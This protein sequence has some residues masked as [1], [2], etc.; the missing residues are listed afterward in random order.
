MALLPIGASLYVGGYFSNYRGVANSA[1][2]LAKL[3]MSDGSIDTLFSQPGVG[4]NGVGSGYVVSLATVGS[5][6]FIGGNFTDYRGVANSANAI[7][8]LSLGDGAIDTTFSP[9]GNNGF[10][11]SVNS[12][13][14]D[15]TSLYVGGAITAYRSVSGSIKY[16]AKLSAAD[17]SLDT[18][19]ITLNATRGFNSTV[20]CL[21]MAGT[22]VYVGGYFS[23]YD[24]GAPL[25]ATNI[26]KI[27]SVSG[28][29]DLSFNSSGSN[30]NGFDSS[31]E[32]IYL[33]NSSLYVSGSF[34]KFKNK[35]A[36]Y[37]VPLSLTGDLED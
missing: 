17:G 16:L 36:Y 26:A 8:K 32:S 34:T 18:N 2:G 6:L 29:Q 7:A 13:V 10:S 31:V 25:S 15:G 12:I 1:L 3:N 35:T 21:A 11:G 14:T 9:P 4:M 24:S 27:D 37:V 5:Y 20:N 30:M 19:F 28:V 22:N 33:L 23:T